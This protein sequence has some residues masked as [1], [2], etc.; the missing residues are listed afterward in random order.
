[1][2]CRAM[3]ALELAGV[4]NQSVKKSIKKLIYYTHDDIMKALEGEKNGRINNTTSI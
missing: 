1:M 2:S 4:S 3:E